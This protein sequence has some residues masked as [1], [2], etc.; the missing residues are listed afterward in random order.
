M[1]CV[2]MGTATS[3]PQRCICSLL[4]HFARLSGL[5]RRMSRV[6]CPYLWVLVE[7]CFYICMSVMMQ[8]PDDS[9]LRFF[10][11]DQVGFQCVSR[12]LFS[13]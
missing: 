9:P 4:G 6:P 1:M 10:Q 3:G 11:S 8:T 13:Q 2:V 5:Y 12:C 7:A